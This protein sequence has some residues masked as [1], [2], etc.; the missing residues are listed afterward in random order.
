MYCGN[1]ESSC[2]SVSLEVYL[3]VWSCSGGELLCGFLKDCQLCF[4]GLQCALIVY[5]GC[6]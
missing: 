1:L 6:E 5:V 4:G 2:F 3:F